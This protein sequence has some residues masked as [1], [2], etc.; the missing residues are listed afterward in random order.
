MVGDIYT[1]I[2]GAPSWDELDDAWDAARMAGLEEDI[3]KMPMGMHTVVS[4]GAEHLLRRA[5]SSG[6]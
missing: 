5:R 1:N 2:V 6:C 3:K 4:E